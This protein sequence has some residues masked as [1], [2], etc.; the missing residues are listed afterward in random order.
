MDVPTEMFK[1]MTGKSGGSVGIDND[2]AAQSFENVGAW[3]MG[4]NVFGPIRGPW[5][6]D[7]WNGWWGNNPPYHT[8]VFVLTQYPRAAL[9]MKG[10]TTFHFATD[11]PEAVTSGAL[12][13]LVGHHL[14][15][16]TCEPQS[17]S[18]QGEGTSVV[19]TVLAVS[20]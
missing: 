8:P 9:T 16:R 3:T 15:N 17:A 20:A 4:R 6:D 2:F 7:A 1:K 19:R 11:G 14:C 18:Y 10:G 12:G 5:Q 13:Q